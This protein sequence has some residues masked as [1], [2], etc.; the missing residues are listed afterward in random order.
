MKAGLIPLLFLAAALLP[1]PGRADEGMWLFSEFPKDRV[2]QKYNFEVNDAFLDR[3]R[4]SS[5]KMGASASFVS[6]RGLILTNHHVGLSCVQKVSSP[7]HNYVADGFLARSEAGELRCPGT[8]ITVLEKIEDVTEQVAGAAKAPPASAEANRQRKAAMSRIEQACA[9]GDRRCDVVTLF[10]GARYHL[11]RYKRYTDVRLVF[12]PEF[13]AGFFGGDPDNFTYPR[14]CLDINFFR[15]YEDGHPAQTPEYLRWSRDGAREGELVFV[16]GHPAGSS[17]LATL[18]ELEFRRDV[19]IPAQLA[20]LK[21][22]I[23]A[24]REYGAKD[25]EAERVARSTMFSA[26][27]SQKRLVGFL[28]GLRG[29]RIMRIKED[30][31]TKLRAAVAADAKV[32]RDSGKVWDEAAH[33]LRRYTAIH[34]RYGILETGAATGSELFLIARHL[35]RLAEENPKPNDLRL[36]EYADSARPTLERRLYSQ[37]PVTASFEIAVL[38]EYLDALSATLGENDAAVKTVLGGKTAHDAARAYVS[39]SRLANVEE[40]KRLAAG[41]KTLA[42][43]EDGM[44]LLA[45]RLDPAARRVRKQFEDEVEAALD[46]AKSK[47]AQARF[48][49]YGAAEYPDATATL[50]LSYGVVKGY[51]DIAGRDVPWSTNFA[52]AFSRATGQ[53]PFR[54]PPS[55]LDARSRLALQMPF[56]FVA[57]TDTHG[58]N[59]GSPTINTRGELVGILFDSNLEKLPNEF[60]YTED[61]ARSVHVA[62]QG[63]LESLR[64]IYRAEE[65][66]GELLGR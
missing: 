15:A 49:L 1:A 54:L 26:E 62:G 42:A 19:F 52:G 32:R 35:V 31:E 23:A 40:R 43:S 58:G 45:R 11:Y 27:N 5:V 13:R 51:R 4:L 57:T 25:P 59:S 56:N 50:R 30:Q 14:Y 9:G 55:W 38:S 48:T 39:T 24:L 29:P 7:D 22:R 20:R 65:L 18:A 46:G 21:S 66:V 44:I 64:S 53:D 60:V 34:S 61:G 36:R 3:L 12:T 28:A 8:E 63:I 33:A 2:R 47:I 37:A 6:P 16:S 41:G 17:R 10:A